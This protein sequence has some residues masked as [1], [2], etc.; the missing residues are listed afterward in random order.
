VTVPVTVAE[1][2]PAAVALAAVANVCD[3]E[4]RPARRFESAVPGL[5]PNAALSERLL[6]TVAGLAAYLSLGEDTVREL[7]RHALR[8][9]VVQVPAPPPRRGRERESGQ[10]R[11]L[12]FDREVVN[13]IV[14]GWRVEEA[15]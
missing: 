13:A 6:L 8:P 11:R 12:L 9:A 3:S 15:R 4:P 10:L 14:A 5:S 2:S 7:A 1:A